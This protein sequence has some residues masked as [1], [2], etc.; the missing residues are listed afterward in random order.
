M[1][2]DK[3]FRPGKR[4]TPLTGFNLPWVQPAF[5]IDDHVVGQAGSGTSVFSGSKTD[6]NHVL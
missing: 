5:E 2:K 4:P 3:A 6:I 1:R